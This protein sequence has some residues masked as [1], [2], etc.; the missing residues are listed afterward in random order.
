MNN[1]DVGTVSGGVLGGLIG[2]RFGGGTGQLV[3]IGAG[4]VLGAYLGGKI[5]QTMDRQDQAR[6]QAAL[7][8]NSIGQPAYWTNQRTGNVYTV[9][10]VRNVT[11]NSNRYCREYRTTANI[12]GK[13]QQIYGTA[14]RQQDGTWKVVK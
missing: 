6:M 7:E 13:Q 4:A 1:Q 8:G 14:C 11:V 2:S 3:A 10:P 12:A 5:G 9:V